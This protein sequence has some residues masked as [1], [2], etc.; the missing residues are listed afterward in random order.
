M[1]LLFN[2]MAAFSVHN[3]GVCCWGNCHCLAE[4]ERYVVGASMH[5]HCLADLEIILPNRDS[6]CKYVDGGII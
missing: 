5:C 2:K 3:V 6:S 4:H 1:V